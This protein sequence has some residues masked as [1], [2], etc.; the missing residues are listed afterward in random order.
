MSRGHPWQPRRRVL[1]RAGLHLHRRSGAA[2][3]ARRTGG[4]RA[5]G[6]RPRRERESRRRSHG[7]RRCVG[8]DILL[9][10]ARRRYVRRRDASGASRGG[11]ERRAPGR[12]GTVPA[13]ARRTHSSMT[14]VINIPPSLDDKTFESVLA[15]LEPIPQ[16]DKVLLD[17]RHTRWASPYGL[18]ALL[19]LAQTR[20]ERPILHA[21]E[22]EETGS[23]WA[24]TGFFAHAAELFELHGH[25]PRPRG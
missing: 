15:R 8:R 18:T 23:Y 17:A 21:P 20:A 14:T 12:D 7:V 25:V 2:S 5:D 4:T 19:T 9:P 10:I 3:T 24:R 16:D 13:S 22:A 1:R 6:A 11:P